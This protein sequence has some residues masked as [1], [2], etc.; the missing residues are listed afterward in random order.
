MIMDELKGA[1]ITLGDILTMMTF[2]VTMYTLHKQNLRRV[3][4]IEFRVSLMWKHF[5]KR[6]ALPEDVE[7][8]V[9]EN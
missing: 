9:E 8:A 4:G 3:A 7:H 2:I 5:A 6:F 1:G